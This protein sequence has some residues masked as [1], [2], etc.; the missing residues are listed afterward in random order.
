MARFPE[1]LRAVRESR[2]LTQAE[3]AQRSGF[4]PSAVSH[5]ERGRRTPTVQN[6]ERLADT[7]GVAVDYLLGRGE[8]SAVPNATAGQ[9]PDDF[10]RLSREEQAVVLDLIAV[11]ARRRP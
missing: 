5:F 6:I 8:R 7:L 4:Q 10:V 3:L 11:L 1:T 9:L 2:G